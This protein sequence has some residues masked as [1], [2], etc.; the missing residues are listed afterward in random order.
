MND[1]VQSALA[2]YQTALLTASSVEVRGEG[3][4]RLRAPACKAVL[5]LLWTECIERG[6]DVSTL[7]DDDGFFDVHNT[8]QLVEAIDALKTSIQ[9]YK[10]VHSL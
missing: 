7:H 8:P 5:R 1:H 2:S 6:I 4:V 9:E 10:T 3:V